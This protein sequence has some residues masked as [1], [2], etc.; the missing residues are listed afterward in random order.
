MEALGVKLLSAE[1]GGV[2]YR[3]GNAALELLRHVASYLHEEILE[4]IKNSPSIG[5][6]LDEKQV[7]MRA[8]NLDPGKRS[9][10]ATDNTATFTGINNGVIARLKRDFGL[11]FVELNACAAHSFA[12]VGNQAVF[13]KHHN[14]EKPRKRELIC[15][16][17]GILGKM[18]QHFA[19]STTRTFKLKCWQ[20]LLEIPE[21]KFKRLFQIRW[22]AIRNSIKP[23]MLDI[24]PGNQA[25][26]ATLQ[27]SKFDKYLT[28]MIVKQQ[29]SS[30]GRDLTKILQNDDLPY[31]T[32][33]NIL[34]E[35][36]PILNNWL[37]QKKETQPVLGPSLTEYVN[38]MK[39]N[40]SY[41]AFSITATD[42]LK[43][44]NEC[45]THISQ[46]LL[47]IDHRFKPSKVQQLFV[48]LFEPDYLIQN[49]DQVSK[50]NYGR[51]EI[52]YL[53]NKYKNLSD[54]NM[55][56]CRS[57]W[58]IIKISLSEFVSNNQQQNSRR[59]FW[60]SFIIW[61][62]AT[63]DSFRGRFKN[64]LTLLS[65]YLISPI[66]S[67][68]CERGYSVSNRIQTNARSRMMINTLDVLMN[69]RL[70]F[71]HDLRS[72][73]CR[74]IIE[75][76]YKSWNGRDENRRIS[77]TKLIVD[78]PDDYIPEKQ[79]RLTHKQKRHLSTNDD[80]VIELK[81]QKVKAIKCANRCGKCIAADDPTEIHAIQCCH[82]NEY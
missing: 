54:F 57:E 58:E 39:N 41:G 79:A 55:S 18:Y 5:W 51:Q 7:F 19:S 15:K 21:L 3:N 73:K 47:E 9:W 68:E 29:Q 53:L 81:K 16:L 25:L 30:D 13:I 12:L 31:F 75:R 78:I 6:M 49:K 27:E 17:E 66:N 2:C 82:Q 1:I 60:K 76:A 38:H 26:L 50:S 48:T 28:N 35:K 43:M 4:K 11:D 71:P 67:C 37:S 74:N 20:N 61:K 33:M 69:I 62:E 8:D 56:Q 63:D 42:R 24:V 65:I 45:F 22:T 40:N 14:E 46:L 10:F 72:D 36:K 59:K 64:V 52:E 77:R 23:I 80:C 44:H 32:F 34:N 70:L